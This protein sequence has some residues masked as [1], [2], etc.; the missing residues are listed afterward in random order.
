MSY[1]MSYE[2]RVIR[3][4][5]N[6]AQ[7]HWKRRTTWT[8]SLPV[9][10]V[11]VVPEKP[12]ATFFTRAPIIGLSVVGL[13]L[14]LHVLL[15][16]YFL[17]FRRRRRTLDVS[18][19]KTPTSDELASTANEFVGETPPSILSSGPNEGLSS[20]RPSDDRSSPDI[21]Q[22]PPSTADESRPAAEPSDMIE[23]VDVTDSSSAV[24]TETV[25]CSGS[26]SPTSDEERKTP[27]T[28]EVVEEPDDDRPPCSSGAAETPSENLLPELDPR[29]TASAAPTGSCSYYPPPIPRSEPRVWAPASH[30]VPSSVKRTWS[31]A[32]ARTVGRHGS[33]FVEY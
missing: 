30:N 32:A 31:R 9:D 26:H 19:S 13:L 29:L 15:S 27:S 3:D 11:G 12:A 1:I 24:T 18:W 17:L 2:L 4:D 21:Q 14:L 33:K 7:A 20:W 28:A 23:N 22:Q 5:Y 25:L 10:V 6:N 16:L 8:K